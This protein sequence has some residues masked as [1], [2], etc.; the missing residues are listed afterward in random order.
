MKLAVLFFSTQ[1]LKLCKL[2]AMD[3]DILV[4]EEVP[5]LWEEYPENYGFQCISV[6]EMLCLYHEK[7][8]EKILVMPAMI[9]TLNNF[10]DKMVNKG[11]C[12]EHILY[13]PIEETRKSYQESSQILKNICLFR[14]R[15]D[16][17]YLGI[18]VFDGCNFKCM[19]CSMLEGA[20]LHYKQISLKKTEES[21]VKLN[22]MFKEIGLIQIMGGEPLLNK[23]LME[24][25][26]MVRRHYPHSEIQLLTNGSL[27]FGQKEELF[28]KIRENRIT[29]V[30]SR[31][32]Q[33]DSYIENI[34][35]F[36]KRNKV[37]YCFTDR[38]EEFSKYYDFK[39]DADIDLN[40]ELC[41]SM[42][43]CKNGLQLRENMIAPCCVPFAL[44]HMSER[45]GIDISICTVMNLE[46]KVLMQDIKS[47]L[48]SPHQMCKVCHLD[49]FAEWKQV[50]PSEKSN[51]MN[52]SI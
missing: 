6:E 15:R 30:I 31:Y 44:E 14:D 8:I 41:Q 48:N 12:E 50:N 7:Q 16:L 43:Y 22:R 28:E 9:K 38:I 47:M 26:P 51:I 19:H 46:S 42:Q 34:N 17:D 4:V 3:H 2:L 33:L 37:Q 13:L 36:L 1:Y 39:Q 18:H 27:I 21:L 49:G 10:V 23:Q 20:A 11:I 29:L 45:F 25:L 35:T 24:Y 52:W 32:P 40:F 5:E